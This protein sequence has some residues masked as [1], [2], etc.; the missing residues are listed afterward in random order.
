VEGT[1]TPPAAGPP[2]ATAEASVAGVTVAGSCLQVAPGAAAAGLPM[3]LQGSTSVEVEAGA[4]AQF[5]LWR[6][7]TEPALTN[8]LEAGATSVLTIP[9]DHST[10]PWQS[11]LTVEGGATVCTEEQG[12]GS[13]G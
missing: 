2:P 3:T 7:A 1:A 10:R 8:E 4:P 6:F 12:A 5:G 13:S 11:L 9:P